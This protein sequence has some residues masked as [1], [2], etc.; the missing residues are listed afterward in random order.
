MI[1]LLKKFSIFS[2]G[3]DNVSMPIKDKMKLPKKLGA[4][5][6]QQQEKTKVKPKLA[7]VLITTQFMFLKKQPL[8]FCFSKFFLKASG[9]V[10]PITNVK[11]IVNV[12]L[13]TSIINPYDYAIETEVTFRIE[14]DYVNNY[15]SKNQAKV[16]Y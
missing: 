4:F 13:L 3:N 11:K 15:F 8:H 1:Q 9:K 16:L 6:L 10:R 14:F 12:N 7:Q 2:E 5:F